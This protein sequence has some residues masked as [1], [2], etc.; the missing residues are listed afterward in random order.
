MFN[1]K[2]K[3]R[4]LEVERSMEL[5][6]RENRDMIKII[7]QLECAHPEN[8]CSLTT[9][10]EDIGFSDTRG[11]ITI[12]LEHLVLTYTRTCTLC[13]KTTKISKEEYDKLVLSKAKRE[14]KE[15][16]AKV[17][18]LTPAPKKKPTTKK[19]K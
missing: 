17:K 2:L 1:R 3:Q 19:E 10:M 15:A 6:A 8:E 5:L 16:M 11:A 18:A 9:G 7:R 4:V 14:V 13:G 12:S